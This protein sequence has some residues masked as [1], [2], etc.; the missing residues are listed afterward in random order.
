MAV[1]TKH[2]LRNIFYLLI[3]K[4]RTSELLKEICQ[5]KLY[6]RFLS[7][8]FV[9]SWTSNNVLKRPENIAK[10]Q[11]TSTRPNS[12]EKLI[13]GITDEKVQMTC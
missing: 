1:N 13:S 8:C 4:A 10:V 3:E 2:I 9:N 7:N 6:G 5:R 11:N 12:L